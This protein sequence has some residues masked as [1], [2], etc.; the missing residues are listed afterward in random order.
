MAFMF[1]ISIVHFEVRLTSFKQLI[2]EII[3]DLKILFLVIL[4]LMLPVSLFKKYDAKIR[5]IIDT[6]N[7]IFREKKIHWLSAWFYGLTLTIFALFLFEYPYVFMLNYFQ[8]DS[9]LF[10]VYQYDMILGISK[11]LIRNT[12]EYV[13]IGEVRT[14]MSNIKIWPKQELFPQTIYI[15]LNETG[16]H[17][18]SNI[19]GFYVPNNAIHFINV[20]SKYLVFI[21]AGYIYL[22]P[23]TEELRPEFRESLKY[24]VGRIKKK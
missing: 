8:Y 24:L 2:D 12:A 7:Y 1:Y 22:G 21:L 6:R 9:L 16:I 11:T 5:H 19:D 20:L 18:R 14:N 10:P 13:E 23:F 3:M 17:Q 4:P 15:F